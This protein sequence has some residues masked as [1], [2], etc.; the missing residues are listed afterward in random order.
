MKPSEIQAKIEAKMQE[1]RK[2]SNPASPIQAQIEKKMGQ[3][4][5]ENR[6]KSAMQEEREKTV[7]KGKGGL[8]ISNLAP[9]LQFSGKKNTFQEALNWFIETS[10]VRYVSDNELWIYIDGDW[11]SLLKQDW[12]NNLPKLLREMGLPSHNTEELYK[13]IIEAFKNSDP[14]YTHTSKLLE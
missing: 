6:I 14:D 1:L 12:I 9:H 3:I 11:Y 8:I 13:D 2:K 10:Q 5:L 4:K 7:I